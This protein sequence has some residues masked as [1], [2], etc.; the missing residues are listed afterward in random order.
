MKKENIKEKF[1]TRET[2][3]DLHMN[4]QEINKRI[5]ESK[6]NISIQ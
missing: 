3:E 4:I 1:Y 5:K 6:R 2:Q